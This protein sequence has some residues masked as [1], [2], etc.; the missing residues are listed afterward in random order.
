MNCRLNSLANEHS[1]SIRAV[2]GSFV[3]TGVLNVGDLLDEI[4]Y[5]DVLAFGKVMKHGQD[6]ISL[7]RFTMICNQSGI[8]DKR[9]NYQRRPPTLTFAFI[10]IDARQ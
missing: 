5:R 10:C 6:L 7:I 4:E 8:S 9:P 3:W 2:V 1:D